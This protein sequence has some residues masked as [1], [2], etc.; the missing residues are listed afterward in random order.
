MRCCGKDNGIKMRRCGAG[1]R[2]DIWIGNT[3][4]RFFEKDNVIG[5]W[6]HNIRVKQCRRDSLITGGAYISES[7]TILAGVGSESGAII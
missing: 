1:R 3:K 4:I 2:I 6:V 5:R 7:D